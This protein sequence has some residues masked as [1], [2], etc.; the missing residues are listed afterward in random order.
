MTCGQNGMIESVGGMFVYCVL[1]ASHGFLPGMLLGLRANWE[2]N[3]I[4]N[5]Q[6]AYGQEWVKNSSLFKTKFLLLPSV[7]SEVVGE[8]YSSS[9]SYMNAKY[10]FKV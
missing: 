4:N 10:I 3:A 1:L 2:N 9:L 8:V 7:V 5:L 6:D